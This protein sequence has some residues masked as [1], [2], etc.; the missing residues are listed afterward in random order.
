[1]PK[2]KIGDLVELMSG[3]PTMTVNTVSLAASADTT[4]STAYNCVWFDDRNKL[5]NVTLSED[6][7]QPWEKPPADERFL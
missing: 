1:M 4:S 6:A 7:I 5:R 3:G 2:F